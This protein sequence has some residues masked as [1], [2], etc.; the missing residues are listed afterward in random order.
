MLTFDWPQIL[1]VTINVAGLAL[2]CADHGRPSQTNA[3]AGVFGLG[4]SLSLLYWGGF[5]S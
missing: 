3:W 1:Y 4:V 5:F 2:M